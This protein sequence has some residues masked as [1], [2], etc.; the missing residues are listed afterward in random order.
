MRKWNWRKTHTYTLTHRRFRW[1]VTR[2]F[3]GTWA[4]L[5][6][7]PTHV[8]PC[9]MVTWIVLLVQNTC[10]VLHLA[11]MHVDASDFN[12][13]PVPFCL[14]LKTPAVRVHVSHSPRANLDSFFFPSLSKVSAY[15]WLTTHWARDHQTLA[16]IAT[17][18]LVWSGLRVTVYWLLGDTLA[19]LSNWG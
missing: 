1:R 18:R 14:A 6:H 4:T 17:L 7:T 5:T 12:F 8:I 10:T 15:R 11:P 13:A 2:R 9:N 3:W 16:R 19:G